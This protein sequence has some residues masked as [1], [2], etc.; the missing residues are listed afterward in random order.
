LFADV[1]EPVRD[2]DLRL[3]G[4]LFES[5]KQRFPECGLANEIASRKR[6]LHV[7]GELVPLD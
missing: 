2:L 5:N 3:Y 7:S 4:S 1:F 6:L